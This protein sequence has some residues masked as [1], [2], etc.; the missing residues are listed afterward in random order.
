MILTLEFSSKRQVPGVL[1]VLAT[2]C[3]N[4][5][6]QN[7]LDVPN[8]D[9][10]SQIDSS[11]KDGGA[12]LPA[13]KLDVSAMIQ[14]FAD[15][16]S[17]LGYARF[18]GAGVRIIAPNGFVRAERFHGFKHLEKSA[19]VMVTTSPVCF[20]DVTRPFYENIRHERALDL[21]ASH[22]ESV[23]IEGMDCVYAYVVQDMGNGYSGK[24]ILAFGNDSK[25]WTV[26]GIYPQP[27]ES[28]FAKEIV[29]SVLSTRLID[30]ENEK[31][32][33][34]V[35]FSL[36]APSLIN[37]PGWTKTVAFTK[38]GIYPLKKTT[39]PFFI[40]TP[41]INSVSIPSGKESA[42][43]INNL[44]PTPTTVIDDVFINREVSI[45]GLFG[46][47]LMALGADAATNTPQLIYMTMLF[48]DGHY[49]TMKGFVGQDVDEDYTTEFG[50]IARSFKRV[51]SGR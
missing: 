38:D 19:S 27:M 49:Y 1:F 33:T 18:P 40:A 46:I 8:Q 12:F 44:R 4:C 24:H 22:V 3:L 2:L 15:S 20:D 7:T 11:E 17:E 32:V 36:D 29:M 41:S 16:Y 47:E 50:A 51:E 10:A 30:L 25:S 9:N 5:G 31:T 23:E 48:D 45:D 34:D 13:N 28:E 42:F 21:K 6:C 26:T 37:T 39:D 35:D 14:E 43:A